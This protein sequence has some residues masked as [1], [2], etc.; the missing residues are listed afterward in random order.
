MSANAKYAINPTSDIRLKTVLV[1]TDFS[2][3]SEKSVRHALGIARYFAAKPYALYITPSYRDI[4][5]S[6]LQHANQL[7]RELETCN[8]QFAFREGDV[9][10][11]LQKF[12]RQRQIELVVVG[13]HGRTGLKKLVLGSVAEK[14]F[15][16]VSCPVVT[17]GPHSPNAFDVSPQET[18]RPVLFATDFCEGYAKA[19]GYAVSFANRRGTRLALLHVLASVPSVDR[20]RWYTAEDV[21]RERNAARIATL[22]R[23]QDLVCDRKLDCSPSAWLNLDHPSRKS[24]QPRSTLMR[25]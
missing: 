14:V 15:R 22:Q 13:T 23:L 5:V 25:K 11:E 2:A 20:N 21:E 18:V 8:G 12:M 1:A 10:K 4:S 9:W 6:D 16:Q 24:S 19:L 7:E 17:V 3:A